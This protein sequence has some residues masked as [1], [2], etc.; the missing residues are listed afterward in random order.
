[1][2]S[3]RILLIGILCSLALPS[4][5]V[6]VATNDG[7]YVYPAASNA[8]F[9]YRHDDE[10]QG[11]WE[12]RG[13]DD[14]DGEVSTGPYVDGKR[15]GRWKIRTTDGEVFTG[16]YVNDDWHGQ[17]DLRTAGS[18]L[19][20]ARFVRGERQGDWVA[21]SSRQPTTDSDS[22]FGQFALGPACD[23]FGLAG[24]RM[25]SSVYTFRSSS[26]AENAIR[27]IT[28]VVSLEPNFR[29]RAASVPNATAVVKGDRRYILY[30]RTFMNDMQ[31]RTGSE[32][33]ALS[34][35]AHEIGHHLQG[36]TLQAGGSRPRIEL[37][38]DKF[39]GGVLQKLGANLTDAQIAMRT[40]GSDRGS[41]THPAKR[42]RLE[43]I[44]AGWENSCERDSSCDNGNSGRVARNQPSSSTQNDEQHENWIYCEY[45]DGNKATRRG[46]TTYFSEFFDG[47][48]LETYTY[49][50]GFANYLAD[51]YRIRT[52][53]S[54]AHCTYKG[55]KSEVQSELRKS[56]RKAKARNRQGIIQTPWTPDF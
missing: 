48:Q 6:C 21:A 24:D 49:Q 53:R 25:P 11:R 38:A 45:I 34:I 5:A 29:V 16:R 14:F 50:R 35:M 30:S 28:D 33:A 39:S 55:T 9:C 26:D 52:Y 3:R 13:V 44:A 22:E 23:Y 4:W 46:S 40:L 32:W 2:K 42:D 15:H 43:A 10:W 19:W 56:M 51:E 12:V 20:T 54:R 7:E 41:S 31:R 47:S 17:W 36:H 1:M 27:S 18:N 37:E 8:D